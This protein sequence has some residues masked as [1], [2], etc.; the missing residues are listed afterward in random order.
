M[1]EPRSDFGIAWMPDG[2]LFAIGGNRGASGQTSSVEVLHCCNAHVATTTPATDT[3]TYVAPLST[4]RQC[5]AVTV[6]EGKI[7]VAGGREECGVEYFAPPSDFN[8]LGQWT[9]IYPLPNPIKLLS[10]LP[11]KFGFIGICK[12]YAIN[13]QSHLNYALRY[14]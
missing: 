9:S 2:R 4:A 3:W 1:L 10:L 5:H 11:I 8:K 14:N 13:K 12:A 7:I 6:L